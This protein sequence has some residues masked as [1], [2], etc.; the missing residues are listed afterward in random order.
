MQLP[1][2]GATTQEIHAFVAWCLDELS[3]DEKIYLMSGHGFIEQYLADDGQYNISPYQTGGGNE[4]LGL[5]KLMF[6]DGPRGVALGSSTCFP[7][8]MARGASWDVVLEERIGEAIGCETRA[9]G[10]NFFGGVCINLLRHPA[11]GRAQETYGEDPW[12]LGE[13]GASLVRGVQ[14]HNV[15]ATVKHFACN[16]IENA[17]FKVDVIVGERELRE[18]YL[19]HFKRCIDEG[20]ASVMSAYN[21]VNGSYCGHNCT[22][23]RT[24]LKEEWGFQGFVHSDFVKGVYGPDA[25]TAGLDVENPETVF[26]GDQLA[27]AVERGEVSRTDVDEAAR[28]IL[29]TLLTFETREDPERYDVSVVAC[30]EHRALAREAAEKSAVLL[31]NEGG[32]LP[33]SRASLTRIA[34]VGALADSVSLGDRGSS[35]VRPPSTVS[36]LEGVCGYAGDSVEVIHDD[37]SNVDS[38]VAVACASEVAVVVVGYTHEDEGEFVPGDMTMEGKGEGIGG[39][40][41]SL[42][43]SG[44]DEALILAVAAANAHTVVVVVGGSAITMERWHHSVDAILMLWYAGMEGGHAAAR[45][46]FGEVSPSGKLPFTIPR[47]AADL[48]FFDKEAESIEYGLYHGYTLLDRDQIQPAYCFGFG[49]SYARF[50]YGAVRGSVDGATITLRCEV[51]NTGGCAAEEIV[52]CYVGFEQSAI[53]RPKKLLRGF[54]KLALEPGQSREVVFKLCADDLAYFDPNGGGWTI[55]PIVYTAWVA[56]T[57]ALAHGSG[58]EFSASRERN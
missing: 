45:L 9:Q 43:L 18:V 38:A 11:W 12:H 48:P 22:L 36:V 50:D 58:F 3:L 27:G 57:S 28:R 37:G 41:D 2:K 34:V 47:D 42:S 51:T 25:V 32:R 52:Q 16:S 49:L 56:P 24:I 10:S 23:L 33:L 29:T 40:R 6:T 53:D 35:L 19:P 55:E 46:L 39:D 17:R 31:R 26:F 54:R 20:V 5:P 4:R 8:A 15:V 30:P 1:A 14:R 13:M 21:K 7:V 44:A